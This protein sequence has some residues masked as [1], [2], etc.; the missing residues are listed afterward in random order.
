MDHDPLDPRAKRTREAILGAFATL[1]LGRRYDAIRIADLIAAAGVGRST[2]YEHFPGK[3]AVLV[4]AVEPILHT[5]AS[6]ALGRATKVQVRA[7]LDHVWAQRGLARMLFEGRTGDRLQRRLATLIAARLAATA[8]MPAVAAAAA[9]LAMLRAWIR[10]EVAS[11]AAEL[12]TLMIACGRLL[13][14][15]RS[16]SA[17]HRQGSPARR[18]P[19]RP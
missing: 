12:A 5:L 11:P 8:T 10:G 4:A 7:M 1:A 19:A 3:D 14:T 13:D 17:P 2:F 9:Q 18:S 15:N 16:G 6:A